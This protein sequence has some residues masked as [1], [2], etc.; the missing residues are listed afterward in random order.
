[1]IEKHMELP[2]FPDVDITKYV[3]CTNPHLREFIQFHRQLLLMTYS[4]KSGISEIIICT[5]SVAGG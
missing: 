5:R 1:M 4:V 2:V 3:E